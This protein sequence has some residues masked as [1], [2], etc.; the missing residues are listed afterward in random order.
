MV[1]N[2]IVSLAHLISGLTE[3]DWQ[4]YPLIRQTGLLSFYAAISFVADEM[5][6]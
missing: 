5:L 2:K 4:A 1:R 6:S 3:P